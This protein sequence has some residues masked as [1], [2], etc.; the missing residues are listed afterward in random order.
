VRCGSHCEEYDKEMFGFPCHNSGLSFAMLLLLI[1]MRLVACVSF[2]EKVK[3]P[4]Y[5]RGL[6]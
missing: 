1:L 5:I 3:A 6:Y 4:E 2:G